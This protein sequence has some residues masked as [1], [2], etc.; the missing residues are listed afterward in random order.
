METKTYE[1]RTL[2]D[3]FRLP[4]Y[5]KVE[6]CLHDLT[7]AML[8]ARATNDIMANIIKE[9]G[10]DVTNG[11]VFKWPE[12]TNWKDDGENNIHASYVTHDGETLMEMVTTKN[13]L[14]NT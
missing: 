14:P 13:H 4:T 2:Q 11:I 1:I 10:K 5:E 7:N 12:I 3:I 9:N 6:K 8:Q